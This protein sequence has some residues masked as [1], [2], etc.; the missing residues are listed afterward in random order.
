M[1]RI[2]IIDENEYRRQV[3]RIALEEEKYQVI[4]A[5]DLSEAWTRIMNVQLRP[6]LILL[7]LEKYENRHIL[8]VLAKGFPDLPVI[9]LSRHQNQAGKINWQKNWHFVKIPFNPMALSDLARR[10]LVPVH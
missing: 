7:S 8:R 6:D 10:I 5:N 9:I 4:V 1:S 2:M 3:I